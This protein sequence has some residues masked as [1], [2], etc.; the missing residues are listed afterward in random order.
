MMHRCSSLKQGRP[1]TPGR[2]RLIVL[3]F[4]SSRHVRAVLIPRRPL[5]LRQI[6]AVQQH[7][8]LTGSQF[9]RT[10]AGREFR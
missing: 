8:S 6:N 1:V 10:G 7:R 3:F 5:Q 4:D 9:D 2:Y